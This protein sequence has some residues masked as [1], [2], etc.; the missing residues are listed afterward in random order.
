MKRTCCETSATDSIIKSG[1]KDTE[2]SIPYR[3][4]KTLF[5]IIFQLK[6]FLFWSVNRKC[7]L[8]LQK[9]SLHC[10]IFSSS[11]IIL[12]VREKLFLSLDG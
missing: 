12:A 1:Q 11:K 5:F 8:K 2:G 9:I 10:E 3:D 6:P 7:F 4:Q